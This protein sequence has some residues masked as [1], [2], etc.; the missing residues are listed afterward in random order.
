[1]WV[2]HD[3]GR[4]LNPLLVEGQIEGSVYMALG[5][6]LLENHAFRDGVHLGPSLLDYKTPTA[7]DMPEVVSIVVESDDPEG[8]FGA[9][10]VGQG[11]LLPVIPAV[12]NAVHDALGVRIDEVPIT[13][14]KVIRA[15]RQGRVGP[16]RLPDFPFREAVRVDPPAQWRAAP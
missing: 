11:V 5:E 6:A 8:P 1:M 10:E 3:V 9:K 16:K 13:A 14:D 7:L 2:A 12:A 15:L 4:A